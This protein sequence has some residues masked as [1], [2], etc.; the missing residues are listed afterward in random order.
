MLFAPPMFDE[1]RK[2]TKEL[3]IS[4]DRLFVVDDSRTGESTPDGIR[5]WSYLLETPG[6]D[7]YQWGCRHRSRKRPRRCFFRLQG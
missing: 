4:T 6:G 2:A 7:S 5:Q 3:N 1:V